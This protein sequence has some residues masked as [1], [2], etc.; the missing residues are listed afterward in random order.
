MFR[1]EIA[2]KLILTLVGLGVSRAEYILHHGRFEDLGFTKDDIGRLSLHLDARS[3][4]RW[5]PVQ[6][7][8][9]LS[10][11]NAGITHSVIEYSQNGVTAEQVT[12]FCDAGVACSFDIIK[13]AQ[14]EVAAEQVRPFPDAG[15]ACSSDIIAYVQHGVTAE[16][17]RPFRDAG[18]SCSSDIIAY[19]QREVTAEQVSTA[20]LELRVLTSSRMCNTRQQL[21]KSTAEQVRSFCDAGPLSG[22]RVV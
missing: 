17:V 7:L 1:S 22:C 21:S 20:M 15:V 19:V 14:H 9:F 3:V 8:I 11:S 4:A 13:Y 5:Q 16:Q 2:V 10:Y 18:V 6:E 12:Q